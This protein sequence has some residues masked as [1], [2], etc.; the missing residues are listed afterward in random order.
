VALLYQP[1]VVHTTVLYTLD[2]L[3]LT[4]RQTALALF[5]VAT[6]ALV[7]LTRPRWWRLALVLPQHMV[8]WASAVGAISLMLITTSGAAGPGAASLGPSWFVIVDL[9][10]TFLIACGH[11]VAVLTLAS[12]HDG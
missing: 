11:L 7:G 9:L 2:L 8:L 12:G 3:F 10:P 1:A 4:T 6:L 5:V